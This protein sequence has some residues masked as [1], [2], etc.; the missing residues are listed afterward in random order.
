MLVSHPSM[1]NVAS[2]TT[3]VE[4]ELQ[5]SNRFS[6]IAGTDSWVGWAG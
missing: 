3:V 1:E 2:S 6:D 4:N 5:S